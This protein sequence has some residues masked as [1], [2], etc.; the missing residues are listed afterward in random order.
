MVVAKHDFD[1]YIALSVTMTI[2]TDSVVARM[3]IVSLFPRLVSGC[4]IPNGAK[5]APRPK[6]FAHGVF[7]GA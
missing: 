6:S 7:T 2:S 5:R 4:N 1:A 3:T